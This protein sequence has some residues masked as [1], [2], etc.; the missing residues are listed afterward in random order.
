MSAKATLRTDDE[1]QNP[2]KVVAVLSKNTMN[3]INKSAGLQHHIR[4][5]LIAFFLSSRA[6]TYLNHTNGC[7]KWKVVEK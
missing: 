2:T 1:T 7:E 6:V 4:Q 3:T 5:D